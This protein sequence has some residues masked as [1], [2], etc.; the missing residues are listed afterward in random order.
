ML[1]HKISVI[2]V[3]IGC[4]LV[5][6]SITL[7]EKCEEIKN[8]KFC[9]CLNG[10]RILKNE[11]STY[12]S[13]SDHD[14]T[15]STLMNSGRKGLLFDLFSTTESEECYN[16]IKNFI[17]IYALIP[18]DTICNFPNA[19]RLCWESCGGIGKSCNVSDMIMS[20]HC[21]ALSVFQPTK[22]IVISPQDEKNCFP[23]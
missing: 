2:V 11:K 18:F 12:D 7:N 13:L 20:L 23:F 17:C 16:S 9:S 1:L 10:I 15:V 3:L 14:K 5:N 8:M 22:K 4:Q 19:E 21:S 6:S